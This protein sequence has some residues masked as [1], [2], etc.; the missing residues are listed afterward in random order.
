VDEPLLFE[1]AEP[2]S[3]DAQAAR[4]ATRRHWEVLAVC[5]C[6][7]VMALALQ[8]LPDRQHVAFRGFA[9]YPMPHLCTARTWLGMK[10]PGCGLTRSI[11]YLAHGDW[12]ASLRAHRLGWMMA[13]VIA[14]QFPYRLLLLRRPGRPLIGPRACQALAIAI[15]ALLLG[16]WLFDLA[17]G[18]ARSDTRALYRLW[19]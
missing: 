19:F 17:N 7:V 14:F 12:Q 5:G 10:C 4:R 15:I 13:G 11:I 18:S 1:L 6:V 9:D 2:P 16:S 8:V 3:A